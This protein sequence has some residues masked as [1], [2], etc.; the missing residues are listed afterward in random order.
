MPEKKQITETCN[1][2]RLYFKSPQ[3][4]H[5]TYFIYKVRSQQ[6]LNTQPLS[7]TH[8]HTRKCYEY[9][10]KEIHEIHEK[11]NKGMNQPRNRN[12][13]DL[14]WEET[15]QRYVDGYTLLYVG[16]FQ[17]PDFNFELWF[18]AFLLQNWNEWTNEYW[19]MY[20]FMMRICQELK[21]WLIHLI[22]IQEKQRTL[23][24][25]L[26]QLHPQNCP[27]GW[28]CSVSGPSNAVA[29][30]LHWG[31]EMRLVPLRNSIFS[32]TNFN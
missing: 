24:K 31:L 23:S 22:I 26:E 16:Y 4:L 27:R 20:S 32:C 3:K 18:H 7:Y 30:S 5:L 19:V 2:I 21:F 13:G 17:G 6:I 29:T 9:M 12:D 14:R 8:I 15:A 11:E 25:S 10:K 1:N 28:K